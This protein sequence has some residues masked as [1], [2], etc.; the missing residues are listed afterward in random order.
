MPDMGVLAWIVADARAVPENYEHVTPNYTRLNWYT[1][2][3]NA[4][5]SYQTLIT[6]AMNETAEGQGFATDFAGGISDELVS[7]LSTTDAF[8][9]FLADLDGLSDAEYI[10]RVLFEFVFVGGGSFDAR[11]A[12]IQRELPLQDGSCLLYTSPSP[13]DRG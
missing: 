1:G 9:S 6:D 4:Y 12:V 5:A 13:R 10:S 2:S 3:G 8:E 7:Q 11:Q